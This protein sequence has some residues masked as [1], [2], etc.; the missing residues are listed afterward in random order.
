MT[1][2]KPR[3]TTHRNPDLKV[4]RLKIEETGDPWAGKV[5]P[6][7]RLQGC[8][9]ERAGFRQGN[10]VHVKCVALG[11]MELQSTDSTT[12]APAE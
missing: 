8:W 12:P 10:Y 4:R 6:K 3:E 5:R 11:V 9:L 2:D 7:I 1:T